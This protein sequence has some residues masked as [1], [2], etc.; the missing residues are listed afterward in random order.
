MYL[1]RP[2]GIRLDFACLH[3]F[4]KSLNEKFV[5]VLA[6]DAKSKFDSVLS[7]NAFRRYAS[8]CLTVGN[9]RL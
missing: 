5:A 9:G 7:A 8:L 3:R 2:G 6:N 4:F 1:D